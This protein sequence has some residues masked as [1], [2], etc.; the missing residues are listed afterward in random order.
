[1]WRSPRGLCEFIGWVAVLEFGRS[2]DAGSGIVEKVLRQL[3]PSVDGQ[4]RQ[5]VE[6]ECLAGTYM[7][8]VTVQQTSL[9]KGLERWQGCGQQAGSGVRV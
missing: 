4:R 3:G 9:G 2:V 6:G 8:R 7:E 5:Q 1:V